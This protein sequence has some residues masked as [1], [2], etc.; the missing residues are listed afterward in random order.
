MSNTTANKVTV[1]F[2]CHGDL[3]FQLAQ[4][5]HG[6][7]LTV[8]EYLEMLISQRSSI[9]G[10]Q[11]DALLQQ[12]EQKLSFYENSELKE[13]YRQSKGKT[14]SFRDE[15]GVTRKKTINSLQETYE[16][17]LQLAKTAKI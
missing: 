1:G 14:F 11:N 3:K 12:M 4:E 5:A 13:Y 16:I 7:G 6:M 8:S 17:I 10:K 2:K 15:H 9:H